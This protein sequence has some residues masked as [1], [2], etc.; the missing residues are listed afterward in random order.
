MTLA[1]SL[2]TLLWREEVL[3]NFMRWL[4]W[5]PLFTLAVLY[6]RYLYK[7]HQWHELNT[8]KNT[9]VVTGYSLASGLIVT[10]IMRGSI[11]PF[12]GGDIENAV[13][14]HSTT[15]STINS[16]TFIGNWLQ[17]Q[18][19]IGG[20]IFLYISIA[21]KQRIKETELSNLRL[22]N[23]LKGAQLINLTN[24]LNPHFLF[25]AL[26]NI[27]FTI[28]EDPQK[29][30]DILTALS[31]ILRYSLETSR[32]EKVYLSEEL[33]IIQRYIAIVK[34]QMEDRLNATINIP[35]S[36]HAYLI[37]PM[38]LQ[39]LIEN[40]VKHGIDNLRYGGEVKLGSNEQKTHIVFTVT[41]NIPDTS[42]LQNHNTGIGLKNIE[43][44]LQLLYGGNAS[45]ETAIQDQVFIVTVT[46]PKELTT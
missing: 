36:I 18:L 21:T 5:L 12:F 17:T 24:Q 25:N 39:M 37:P 28:H 34:I 23:S 11:I 7:T 15:A 41:N 40:A 13:T 4:L 33:E 14:Q 45:C 8:A 2:I 31:D 26:N 46:I 10:L 44:R 19:F 20:W 22:Q 3:I 6:Y 29:A 43:Q 30:D 1:Q 27:R 16:Q 38:I 35:E 42:T 32:H 9:L